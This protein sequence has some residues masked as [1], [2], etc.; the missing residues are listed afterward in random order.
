MRGVVI[1]GERIQTPETRHLKPFTK[2]SREMIQ[3][4]RQLAIKARRNQM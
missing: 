4:C 3:N 1:T 2:I